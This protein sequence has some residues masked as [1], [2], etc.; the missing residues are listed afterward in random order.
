MRGDRAS[1]I[2]KKRGKQN[3]K[4]QIIEG[5]DLYGKKLEIQEDG[6][7][8]I[9]EN[10]GRFIPK[11]PVIFYF[12]SPLGYIMQM[13]NEPKKSDCQRSIRRSLVFRTEKEC[14]EYK[15]Y[16]ELL[17]EYSFDPDWNDFD[18]AKWYIYYHYKTNEIHCGNDTFIKYQVHYFISRRHAIEFVEKAGE[19]NVKKFM[20]DIW[21]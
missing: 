3:M 11:G 9:I 21:E 16:L 17:D 14:E 4:K 5:S 20:F 7:L 15:R 18:K 2:A 6:S 19:S 1:K 8:K 12:L 10:K 13:R